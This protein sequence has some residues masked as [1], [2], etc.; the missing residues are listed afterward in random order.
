MPFRR[1]TGLA[2]AL[3]GGLSLTACSGSSGSGSG[4]DAEAVNRTTAIADAGSLRESPMLTERV[5]AG[6]L[7]PVDE[8]L[9]A[10]ADIMVEP[11]HEQI[12]VYGGTWNVPT[13]SVQEGPWDIGKVTEEALFR[14]TDA[15]D[16]VEP[17]VAKGFTV[18]DDLTEYTIQLREGMKWSD[19]HPFTSVDVM[20]WWEHVMVP[21]IFGRSVY[22]AFWSTDPGTGERAMATFSAPDE[23]TVTVTFEHPR[24][25]FLERVAI[26]AKWLFAPAH[27][28]ETVLGEFIGEEAA[29]EVAR[30]RGYEDLEGWYESAAYYYWFWPDRPSL[31]AW[32]PTA[33]PGGE[34]ITW[35]RNPYYFK[36]DPEGGQLPYIDRL[37]L[38]LYQDPSHVELQTLSGHFDIT[39][40]DFAS[41][42]LLQENAEQGDYRVLQWSTADWYSHGIQ[43]NLEPSDVK[44]RELFHDERFR[45]AL[46]VAVDRESLSEQLTL[47]LGAPQQ[48]SVGEAQQFFQDGWAEQWATYDADRANQLLDE[49]GLP[50]AGG[51][52]THADGTVRSTGLPL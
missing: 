10:L 49:I 27:W 2:A 22:D 4:G 8:R 41:F 39:V 23:T 9:P 33:E 5:E 28:M 7:P 13:R 42:T 45:E 43:L 40:F 46:S 38:E 20:F 3:I 19:G 25:M 6:E 47:G 18:N 26:D 21:E 17:N 32:V 44:M 31:R 1:R 52:R 11:V 12:G 15:G 14:F 24:P 51:V 50:L 48:A 36:T 16:A 35:E 37:S 34:Q 29:L 30:E